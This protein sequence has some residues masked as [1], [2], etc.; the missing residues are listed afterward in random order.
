MYVKCLTSVRHSVYR[1]VIRRRIIIRQTKVEIIQ[2]TKVE[3]K[4]E[5]N[6]QAEGAQCEKNPQHPILAPGDS[7]L[8]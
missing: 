5:G 8:V 3:I 1:V 6:K 2:Q 4:I 7:A